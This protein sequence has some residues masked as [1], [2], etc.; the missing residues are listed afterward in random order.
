[1]PYPIEVTIREIY[2]KWDIVTGFPKRTQYGLFLFVEYADQSGHIHT[3]RQCL[4]RNF[5]HPAELGEQ[6]IEAIRIFFEQKMVIPS[7]KS[8]PVTITKYYPE[9]LSDMLPPTSGPEAGQWRLNNF[10]KK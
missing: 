1:M 10:S 5:D 9:E 4:M 7:T 6:V 3:D 8:P 2:L